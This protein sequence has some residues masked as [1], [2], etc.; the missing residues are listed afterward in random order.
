MT[1]RKLV[2]AS[3]NPGKIREF[4]QLLGPGWQLIAQ[5]ALGISPVAE[6]GATFYENALLKARHASAASALPAL[7]DDSGIEVDALNGAPGIHS[8]R[9]AGTGASDAAN[10]ARLLAELAHVPEARAHGPLPLLSGFR[11]PRRG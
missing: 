2:L 6:T 10:N 3:A 8:A 4:Q 7:A 1:P 5:P 9:Y 11:A